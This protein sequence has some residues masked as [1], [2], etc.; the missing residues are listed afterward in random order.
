MRAR[1]LGTFLECDAS[2]SAFGHMLCAGKAVMVT[3]RKE[4]RLTVGFSERGFFLGEDLY[5]ARRQVRG[6]FFFW[7]VDALAE[8]KIR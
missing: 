1:E 7:Q 5:K 6:I 8:G 2:E 4:R 3:F